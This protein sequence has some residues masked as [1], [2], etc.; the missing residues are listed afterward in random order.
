MYFVN[1][2]LVEIEMYKYDITINSKHQDESKSIV[3]SGS[4]SGSKHS[5]Q[6]EVVPEPPRFS[7]IDPSNVKPIYRL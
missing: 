6:S 4:K 5:K 1:K 2:G 7:V 3:K